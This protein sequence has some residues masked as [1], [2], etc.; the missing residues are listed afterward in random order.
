MIASIAGAEQSLPRTV[1]RKPFAIP[2]W[3]LRLYF[4]VFPALVALFLTV[5]AV[6]AQIP[7]VDVAPAA[8]VSATKAQ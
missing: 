7:D 6:R 8:P 5:Q 4:A 3:A 2:D 1:S